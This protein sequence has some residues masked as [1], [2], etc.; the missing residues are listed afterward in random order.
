M[1]VPVYEDCPTCVS[2]GAK[3]CVPADSYPGDIVTDRD[4]LC[5]VCRYR[6]VGTLEQLD[7]ARRAEKAWNERTD[8]RRGPWLRVLRSRAK[9]PT[10]QV[11]L[12]G[13]EKTE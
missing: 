4:L 12:F 5:A 8:H 11:G 7:Q 6:S 13:K 10:P 3:A 1:T 2:C 9:K